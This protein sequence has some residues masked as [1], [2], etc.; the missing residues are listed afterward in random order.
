[1]SDHIRTG[2]FRNH[3]LKSVLELLI[4]LFV[5]E[6][7]RFTFLHK[8]NEQTFFVHEFHE[9]IG[10]IREIRAFV[11]KRSEII[12]WILGISLVDNVSSDKENE[13][14]KGI[15]DFRGRLMDSRYD[16]HTSVTESF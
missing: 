6:F 14:L 7:F 11:S 10:G 9:I 13:S 4:D 15:E 3:I 1:M 12:H 5:S 2:I 16:I 8:L